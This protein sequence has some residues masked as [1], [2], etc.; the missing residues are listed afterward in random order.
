MH[1]Y[2]LS[3]L[4]IYERILFVYLLMSK[5]QWPPRPTR[6]SAAAHLLGL[7]VR[8]PT[9]AWMSVSYDCW[10]LSGIRLCIGLITHPDE[11]SRA[12]CF[13]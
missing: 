1:I 12:W 11:C 5:Y 10:M 2:L 4:D 6:G 9:G 7:R 13:Q 3:G 8:I